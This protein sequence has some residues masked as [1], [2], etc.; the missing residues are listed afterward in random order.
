M[1]FVFRAKRDLKL[2]DIEANNVS[3]GEYYKETQLIKDLD[4]Q[5]SEFQSKTTR[6][7]PVSKFITPSPGLYTTMFL[8]IITKR[9]HL[10]KIYM[11]QS[12]QM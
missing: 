8:V 2:S 7:L 11:I 9:K 5:S 10:Q 1:A 4:K 12:K 3:P 6:N